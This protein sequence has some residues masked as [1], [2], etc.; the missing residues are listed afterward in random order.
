MLSVLL[1]YTDSDYLFDIFKLFLQDMILRKNQINKYHTGILSY[2]DIPMLVQHWPI[3]W[4]LSWDDDLNDV[5]PKSSST[6]EPTKHT[7]KTH[8]W[9]NIYLLYGLMGLSLRDYYLS[10]SK[11]GR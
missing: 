4:G 8:H 11:L 5:G 2:A 6:V 9:P 7:M 3:L 10:N 1:R